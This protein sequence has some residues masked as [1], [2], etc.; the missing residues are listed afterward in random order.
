MSAG[1]GGIGVA[2]AAGGKGWEPA[3]LSAQGERRAAALARA[4]K[5]R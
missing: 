2:L 3:P 1:T 5:R 4:D